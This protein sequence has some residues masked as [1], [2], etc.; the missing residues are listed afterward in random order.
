[1]SDPTARLTD[2][3][4]QAALHRAGPVLVTTAVCL[5]MAEELWVLELF[6]QERD[7]GLSQ[8]WRKYL[9]Y[10]TGYG[11]IYSETT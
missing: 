2:R 1:M 8:I 6:Q 5:G 7:R 3:Q 9:I 11:T 4:H 10:P